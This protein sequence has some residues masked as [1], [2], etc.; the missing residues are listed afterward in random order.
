[1]AYESGKSANLVESDDFD[2]ELEEPWRDVK[3]RKLLDIDGDE[4]GTVEEL[5]V[6]EDVPAVHLLKVAGAGRHFLIPVD[7][8]TTVSDEGVSIEQRKDAVWASPE[9]DPQGMP[10]RELSCAIYD[11][12]GYPDPLALGEG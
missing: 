1:M 12:Y 10:V 9:F 11:Y 6:Y 4:V 2:G 3:G 8:V 5:Y 7:A